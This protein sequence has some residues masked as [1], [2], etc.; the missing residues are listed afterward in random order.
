[1]EESDGEPTV[2]TRD[3]IDNFVKKLET[4]EIPRHT[5]LNC[6]KTYIFDSY[7]HHVGVCDQCW[8]DQFPK[9][10]VREFYRSFFE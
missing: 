7:G 9:E 5:C 6:S 2:L 1:M 8:F 10:Q 4:H 3:D